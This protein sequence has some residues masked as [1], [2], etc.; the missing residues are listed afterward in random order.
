MAAPLRTTFLVSEMLHQS[1]LASLA[2]L[3]LLPVLV[4]ALPACMTTIQ[5]VEYDLSPLTRAPNAPYVVTDPRDVQT[6]YTF[7]ICDDVDDASLPAGLHFIP[8]ESSVPAFQLQSQP[9]LAYQLSRP[10]DRG[11][12]FTLY[13]TL[14]LNAATFI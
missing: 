11:W 10:A 7:N 1:A 3:G 5:G 6:N 12:N 8:D 13:G 2:T 9:K 14:V 4:H